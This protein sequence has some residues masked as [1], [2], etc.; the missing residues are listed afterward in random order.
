MRT[1]RDSGSRD[2]SLGHLLPL[3]PAL[4]LLSMVSGCAGWSSLGENRPG[5]SGLFWNHPDKTTK[6]P[7]YDLYADSGSSARPQAGDDAQLAGGD[8]KTGRKNATSDAPVP[9]LVAQAEQARSPDATPRR[10]RQGPTT[11]ASGSPWADRKVCR[12]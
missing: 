3:V 11:P 9:D 5:L 8:K 4:A 7:G 6:S 2:A 10:K 12:H 1:A